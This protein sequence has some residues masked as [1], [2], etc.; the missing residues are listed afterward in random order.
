MKT[1]SSKITNSKRFQGLPDRI[2]NACFFLRRL[3]IPAIIIFI[4]VSV[5]STIWF[6]IRVIPKPSRASYP[7]M[8][9]AM[10][11]MSSFFIWLLSVTASWIAFKKA[12]Q[13][14]INARYLAFSAL[15]LIGIV[16]A[17]V[18]L[19]TDALSVKANVRIWYETN[20]PV[21]IARGIHPGRVVWARNPKIATWDGK[22]GFWWED[23]YTNQE[24]TDI[25]LKE[26][27]LLLTGDNNP[28]DAWQSLFLHFNK[29]KHGRKAGYQKGEK[30]AIKINQ[31]N[32]SGHEN[33]NEINTTPQL[34]LSMLK[35]LINDAG[36][37]EDKI[38]VFDASRFITDN[39]YEKCHPAFPEVSFVDNSGG[40]GRIKAA[41]VTDAIPYSVDNGS[42]ARGLATCAVDADYLINMAVLKGHVGQGVTLCAKNFYGV[43]SIYSDWRKNAHNNFDQNRDGS[44][45]YMTFVDYMGHKDLGEKTLL[46]L[47]D[48]LYSNKFVDNVPSFKWQMEP[49]N[50]NWPSSIF[51]SQDMVAIDAVCMDFILN[52]WPDAPDL[53]YCDM[54]LREAALA[55]NPPSGTAYDPERDG[56][57]IKGSLGVLEHWNNAEEKKYSRNLN[58]G[59][60]IELLYTLF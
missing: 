18:V 24:E 50:D 58:S 37:P 14:F 17:V 7:C 33:T 10:P 11:V 2:K 28:G 16:L 31:N 42:L 59:D 25:L 8:K 13:K 4:S 27:L 29:T 41:Y 45:R 39:I 19:T 20:K 48:G 38:T 15:I 46:F 60:G 43:T 49:F 5:L 30:I 47:V 12:K 56:T 52:E 3:R 40:N 6:I 1:A 36:V 51:V 22:T 9:V 57:V 53:E 21:G 44:P 26:S 54:Y 34:V 35:S 55:G 32:T 23:K